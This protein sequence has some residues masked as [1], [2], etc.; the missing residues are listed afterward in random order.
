MNSN[1]ILLTLPNLL[2]ID[3]ALFV[4]IGVVVLI[5]PT[6][7]PTLTVEVDKFSLGALMDTRR[8][9][10]AMFFGSGLLLS[11]F[12]L[13]VTDSGVL[14]IAARVRLI[15]LLLVI[16]LNL[17]QLRNG[18]WKP[19][20]LYGLIGFFFCLSVLYAYAGFVR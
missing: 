3:G 9:L 17:T 7:Q 1:L 18:R 2:V 15:T 10:A 11:V 19:A 13:Y 4:G 12:G 14:A 20:S 16:G 6:P 5:T 8:L